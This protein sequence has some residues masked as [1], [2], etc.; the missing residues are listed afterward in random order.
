MTWTHSFAIARSFLGTRLRT[1]DAPETPGDDLV[2]WQYHDRTL[3]LTTSVVRQFPGRIEQQVRFG[4]TLAQ[5]R[6][7]LYDPIADPVVRAAFERDVLPR[8]ERSSQVFANYSLFTPRYRTF[9]DVETYDLAEDT[10]LGPN[11]SITAGVAW[12][13][14]GSE[15]DFAHL[16]ASASWT[17]AYGDD[18]LARL[19]L[20]SDDRLDDDAS[21]TTWRP[22]S[23]GWCRRRS[24][25][26]GSWP[27]STRRPGGARARTGS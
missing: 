20:S 11:L 24:R 27:S 19:A 4:H 1:Y 21:S 13:G 7:A 2:P 8:S 16:A 6:P 18:G 5:E 23:S 12:T 10:Q 22:A 9:H 14:I 15:N 3:S 26:A 17:E 25:S